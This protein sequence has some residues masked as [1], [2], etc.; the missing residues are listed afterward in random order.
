MAMLLHDRH[1]L[2]R[3][4]LRVAS[5]EAEEIAPAVVYQRILKRTSESR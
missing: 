2:P 3:R 1:A 4:I 5:V